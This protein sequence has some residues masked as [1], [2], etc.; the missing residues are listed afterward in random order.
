MVI[1]FFINE[2]FNATWN[3]LTC[4]GH[5]LHAR[6]ISSGG[7]MSVGRLL[8]RVGMRRSFLEK[9]AH[10]DNV[11]SRCGANNWLNNHLEINLN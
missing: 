4:Q 8:S 5:G 11:F 3:T 2:K 6:R 1:Y 7:H 10:H 9:V